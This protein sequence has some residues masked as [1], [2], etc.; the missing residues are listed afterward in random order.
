MSTKISKAAIEEAIMEAPVTADA[1]GE[2]PSKVEAATE[3]LK[4]HWVL[5][6]ALFT[7]LGTLWVSRKLKKQSMVSAL[8]SA[9]ATT[10]SVLAFANKMNLGHTP[11]LEAKTSK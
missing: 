6:A 3:V 10:T 11:A 5:A 4:E 7:G 9:V 8:A 2:T 1:V